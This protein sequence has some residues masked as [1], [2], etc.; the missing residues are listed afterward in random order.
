MSKE[1]RKVCGG[2]RT[3]ESANTQAVLVTLLRTAAQQGRD[4]IAMVCDLLRSP[5]PITAN[6]AMP[7]TRGS[8]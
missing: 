8:P 5:G 7:L 3:W 4:A 1:F 6:L 2:N